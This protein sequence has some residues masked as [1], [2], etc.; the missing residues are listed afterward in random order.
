MNRSGAAKTTLAIPVDVR[1][2][3]EGWAKFNQTS[4]SAEIARAVRERAAR[5]RMRTEGIAE[6]RHQDEIAV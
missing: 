4:M 6:R 2:S 1:E 3:L 5:E